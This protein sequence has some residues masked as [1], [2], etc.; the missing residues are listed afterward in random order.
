LP[1]VNGARLANKDL[2]P[3]EI[4]DAI[5]QIAVLGPLVLSAQFG[6]TDDEGV[7]N[8]DLGRGGTVKVKFAN[9]DELRDWVEQ[10]GAPELV[11]DGAAE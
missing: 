8:A 6:L 3:V 5:M 1:T 9:L 2:A 11:E 7:P 10:A 4:G